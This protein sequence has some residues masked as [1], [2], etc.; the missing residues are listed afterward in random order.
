MLRRTEA[1]IIIYL[2][3]VEHPFRT[4]AKMLKALKLEY[5]YLCNKLRELHDR[6]YIYHRKYMGDRNYY[7]FLTAHGKK[8]VEL[9]KKVF[10]DRGCTPITPL[11]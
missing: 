11:K 4:T 5:S 9:A 8:K 10:G 3:Q 6:A 7:Y 2:D 1:R